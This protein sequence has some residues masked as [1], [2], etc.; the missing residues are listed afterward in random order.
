M[1]N[2]CMLFMSTGNAY[3][4]RTVVLTAD[5][6]VRTSRCCLTSF[7]VFVDIFGRYEVEISNNQ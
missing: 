3:Y 6:G 2:I 4:E 7:C 5:T 1:M